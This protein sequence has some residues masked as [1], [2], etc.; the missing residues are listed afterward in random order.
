VILLAVVVVT[1]LAILLS[2][3]GSVT[4][5]TPDPPANPTRTLL[6]QVRDPELLARG[7]VLMGLEG[8]RLNQLWWTEDW[9][10]DQIGVQEVSAAEMGRKTVPY[11]MQT[12]QDQVQVQ[13]NDAWVLDRLAFAGL[14]DAVG[15]VR[16]DVPKQTVYLTDRRQAAVLPQG[17]QTLDGAVAA[18]YVLDAALRDEQERLSRFQSVWDQVLRRFPSDQE[19]AR[20]LIVSLGALSKAT[21]PNEE[22]TLLL[23]DARDLR[24]ADDY[25][26]TQVVLAEDN[27]VRVRPPQGVRRAY[28]VDAQA[29]GD[30]VGD[31]F[32]GFP[33]PPDPVARIRAVQ[34][35][36]V[37]VPTV[38]A[39]LLARSW[40]SVWGG[41]AITDTTTVSVDPS[42]PAVEVVGLEQALGIEPTVEELPLSQ[43]R[44]AVEADDGLPVGL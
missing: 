21:M 29:T 42:V 6:V 19:K 4:P 36:A 44:I 2:Q 30:T 3:Q 16:I 14:V 9:W 41:R 31:I 17:V 38:R 12:V 23:Q 13:V 37:T 25:A 5:P 18:D 26:Q 1:T 39:Q 27:S 28:A 32:G 24:I 15:G 43:A 22:L 8:D 11:V 34:V 33:M 40:Q 7:S 35:R 10:V 20:T